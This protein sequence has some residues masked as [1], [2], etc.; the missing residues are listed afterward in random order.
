MKYLLRYLKRIRTKEIIYGL[1]PNP[2]ITNENQNNGYIENYIN[3]D[4]VGDT[5]TSR[6]TTEYIFISAE[7]PI[8]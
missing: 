3:T 1:R 2:I 6:S 5:F 4:W 8:I 7:K